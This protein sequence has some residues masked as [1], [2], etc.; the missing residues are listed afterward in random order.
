M[1]MLLTILANKSG[2]DYGRKFEVPSV[3]EP[4]G[5]YRDVWYEGNVPSQR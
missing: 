1:I 5:N 2:K 3:S 4:Y